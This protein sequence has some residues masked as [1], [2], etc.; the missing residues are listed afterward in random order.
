MFLHVGRVASSVIQSPRA[1]AAKGHASSRPSTSQ[2]SPPVPS[3]YPLTKHGVIASIYY[4]SSIYTR[5]FAVAL[6]HC[7]Q[8]RA[9]GVTLSGGS[10]YFTEA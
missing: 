10:F 1:D 9:E 2:L 7:A 5:L 6:C 3:V 8:R 4:T